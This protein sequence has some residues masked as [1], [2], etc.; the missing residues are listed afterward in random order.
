MDPNETLESFITDVQ[1]H[2]IEWAKQGYQ[3]LKF[4]LDRGGVV[5]ALTA[6]QLLELMRLATSRLT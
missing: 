5:P 3:D 2:N 1:D 6:D 4:W